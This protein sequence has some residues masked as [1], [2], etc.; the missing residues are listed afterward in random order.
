MS[1]DL[2]GT[3]FSDAEEE[4]EP[5]KKLNPFQQEVRDEQG[6]RRF[7][8]AFTGG[9]SAG[10]FNTVGSKEGWAPSTFSSSRSNRASAKRQSVEDFMDEEDKKLATVAGHTLVAKAE[11]DTL[12]TTANELTRKHLGSSNAIP[13]PI[14]DELIVP[15]SDSIGKKLLALMDKSAAVEVRKA[16]EASDGT[17]RGGRKVYGVA[18]PPPAGDVSV[19]GDAK[20]EAV[21]HAPI[22]AVKDSAGLGFDPLFHAP[23]FKGAKTAAVLRDQNDKVYGRED[24]DQYSMEIMDASSAPTE[25]VSTFGKG[26]KDQ[27]N[28][29]RFVPATRAPP[30][31]KHFAPPE[32]PKNFIPIHKF[33][34]NSTVPN[35]YARRRPLDSSA[36]AEM[37][38]ENATVPVMSLLQSDDRAKLTNR[39]APA[40]SSVTSEVAEPRAESTPSGTRIVRTEQEWRPERLLCKRFNVPD[41][42]AG[43]VASTP[44]KPA[45]SVESIMPQWAP[46]AV[47][48]QVEKKLPVGLSYPTGRPQPP[49]PPV[50]AAVPVEEEVVERA[51]PD[52]FAAIFDAED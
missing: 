9:F 6:R 21:R 4:D 2:I 23:E 15:A 43:Q 5:H 44:A 27:T 35:I 28:V 51:P 19:A 45:F 47:M 26:Y 16:P 13:G 33:D 39:F 37:L 11:Y 30:A 12:G 1:D 48:H 34:S 14:P 40:G 50:A 17:G 3:P 31:S 38:G 10:Y 20:Y 25:T 49:A 8:G 22:V 7:H 18:R 32:V 46:S 52:L 29:I 24:W 41:P 42:F 36:R